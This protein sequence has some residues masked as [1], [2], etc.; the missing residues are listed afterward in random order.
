MLSKLDRAPTASLT[1]GLKQRV[2][3]LPPGQGS[4]TLRSQLQ[5]ATSGIGAQNMDH[6]DSISPTSL[7][8]YLKLCRIWELYLYSPLPLSMANSRVKLSPASLERI[9][10]RTHAVCCYLSTSYTS[11]GSFSTREVRFHV[12]SASW[13]SACQGPRFS[14]QNTLHLT[15]RGPLAGASPKEGKPM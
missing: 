1:R 6:L 12:P 11:S 14:A 7:G 5:S 2:Q 8:I 4:K 13:R 15:Y 9:G 10:S 3:G